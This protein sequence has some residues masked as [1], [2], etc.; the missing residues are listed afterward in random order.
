MSHHCR[1]HPT[2]KNHS[3]PVH[4]GYDEYENYNEDTKDYGGKNTDRRS[5]N[6]P[7]S[8]K[9]KKIILMENVTI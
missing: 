8:A 9:G 4:Y 6:M 1:R 3:E 5:V 2:R 7:H